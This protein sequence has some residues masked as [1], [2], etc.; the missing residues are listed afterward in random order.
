MAKP[1]PHLSYL[2]QFSGYFT[3]DQTQEQQFQ[4]TQVAFFQT[5]DPH[6]RGTLQQDNV[7]LSRGLL[8]VGL[9]RSTERV[10]D[11]VME[12]AKNA[13]GEITREDFLQSAKECASMNCAI[14]SSRPFMSLLE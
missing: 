4:Q 1:P 7:N 6:G 9:K 2:R 5:L 8:G 10:L 13:E 12:N 11:T 14:A 3:T